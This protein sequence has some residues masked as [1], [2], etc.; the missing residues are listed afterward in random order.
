LNPEGLVSLMREY[1]LHSR[2][3]IAVP[4]LLLGEFL[5]ETRFRT[6][7]GHIRQAGLLDA[8][9]LVHEDGIIATLLRVRDSLL[10]EFTIL[11][12]LIVHT[13]TSY[14]GL[15][16]M[17]PWLSRWSGSELHL[18]AAGWYAVLVSTSIFQF[19]LGLGL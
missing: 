2:I 15:V 1:R 12:L 6:I 16:D 13:A 17:T 18:T 10:P 19:L 4:A 3:L 14:R 11:L 8:S 7:I 5:M 9:D